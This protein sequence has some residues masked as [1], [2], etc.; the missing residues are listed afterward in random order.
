MLD[1]FSDTTHFV[2][3]CVLVCYAVPDVLS[4]VGSR[5]ISHSFS[6]Q[7]LKKQTNKKTSVI[8]KEDCPESKVSAGL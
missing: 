8:D 4:S 7:G 2:L 5:S 6:P 1:N 3:S